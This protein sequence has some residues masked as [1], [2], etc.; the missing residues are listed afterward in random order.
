MA[1][2]RLNV[3]L[4][5][6]AIIAVRHGIFKYEGLSPPAPP[7]PPHF[8][9]TVFFYHYKTDLSYC[10]GSQPGG[11]GYCNDSNDIIEMKECGAYEVIRLSKQKALM[12]K[13][14]AYGE[15]GTFHTHLMNRER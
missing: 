10:S 6:I 11:S 12:E 8:S 9:A 5:C 13:N 3:A 1:I 4:S 14:P 15:V 2:L 7:P